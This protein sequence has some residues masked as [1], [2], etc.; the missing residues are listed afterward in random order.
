MYTTF[1]ISVVFVFLIYVLFPIFCS[2]AM[3]CESTTHSDNLSKIVASS[4]SRGNI[5]YGSV[6][7][8]P[9]YMDS[10]M[11]YWPTQY[12]Q[13]TNCQEKHC[14]GLSVWHLYGFPTLLIGNK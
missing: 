14:S 4:P 12:P 6:A 1:K 11:C 9:F 7:D 10:Q 5:G 8:D 3:V 13:T 2:W